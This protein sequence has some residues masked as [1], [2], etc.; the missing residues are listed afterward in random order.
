MTNK[1]KRTELVELNY[2]ITKSVVQTWQQAKTLCP[3]CARQ[4]AWFDADSYLGT[5]AHICTNCGRHYRLGDCEPK[6][7]AG[8]IKRLAI[9]RAQKR[10]A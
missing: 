5:W 3:N 4:C 2:E 7:D 1:V 8:S 6:T 9:L 10:H